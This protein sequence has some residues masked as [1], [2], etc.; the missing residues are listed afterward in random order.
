VN[1]R[2]SWSLAIALGVVL[3]AM[4]SL[5]Q[6]FWTGTDRRSALIDE[7]PPITEQGSSSWRKPAQPRGLVGTIWRG[8]DNTS[9]VVVFIFK[10]D[11]LAEQRILAPDGTLYHLEVEWKGEAD[12]ITIAQRGAITSKFAGSVRADEMFLRQDDWEEEGGNLVLKKRGQHNLRFE[13]FHPP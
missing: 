13:R 12:Q 4:L 1:S 11:R 7:P 3:A 2:A 10:T 9:A 8:T 5:V 6:I